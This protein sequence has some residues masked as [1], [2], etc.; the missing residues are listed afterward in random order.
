MT[1]FK[2]GDR[3]IFVKED[4]QSGWT[5]DLIPGHIY[6]VEI[7]SGGGCIYVEESPGKPYDFA[8]WRLDYWYL[9]YNKVHDKM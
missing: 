4:T 6:T 9:F 1:R 8:R 3:V 7:V 5:R 2:V